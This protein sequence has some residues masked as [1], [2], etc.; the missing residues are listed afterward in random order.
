[1]DIDSLPFP[2]S[3]FRREVAG[4][5]KELI[6]AYLVLWIH[7]WSERG[8]KADDNKALSEVMGETRLQT[9]RLWNTLRKRFKRGDDGLWRDP[10]LEAIREKELAQRRRRSEAG[11]IGA[12]ARWSKQPGRKAHKAGDATAYGRGCRIAH[13]IL[14]EMPNATRATW[15]EEFKRRCAAQTKPLDAYERGG[16]SKTPLYIRC[17]EWVER[18]KRRRVAEGKPWARAR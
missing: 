8:I 13:D 7:Q 1:M 2:W 14:D 6:G 9:A 3:P 16:R 15:N 10:W 5:S 18:T 11:H 4:W 12:E 17:I